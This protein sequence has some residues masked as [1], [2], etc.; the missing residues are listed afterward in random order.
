MSD[1]VSVQKDSPSCDMPLLLVTY[2]KIQ[3][4]NTIYYDKEVSR[5]TIAACS[6]M[7]QK[8]YAGHSCMVSR[9]VLLE[10]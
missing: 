3:Y 9:S 5:K 4:D 10:L 8:H 7:P 1:A 2:D 6:S